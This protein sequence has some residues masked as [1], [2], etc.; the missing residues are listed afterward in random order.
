MEQNPYGVA[1]Q[2]NVKLWSPEHFKLLE[3]SFQQLGRVGNKWLN[4]P[5][6]RGTE[7]GNRDD[8]LIRWVRRRDGSMTYDFTLLDQYLDLAVKYQGIPR[9]INFVVMQGMR[10]NP[11]VDDLVPEVMVFNEG[12]VVVGEAPMVV[13]GAKMS[14]AEKKKIWQPFATALYEHMKVKGLEKAMHWGYPLDSEVDHGFVVMMGEYLPAV[15]WVGGPHQSSYHGYKEPKYYGVIGSVRYFGNLPFFDMRYG[16]K[17]SI[18]HMTIPRIDSSVCSL[19]TASRP[20]GFRV[21]VDHSLAFGRCGFKRVGADEWAS[22]HYDGMR[23][24]TWIVGMPVLHTLWP[25]KNGAESGARFETLIEGVQEGE[26]RLMLAKALD[27]G[28]LKP[29]L[30]KRV[31]KILDRHMETGFFQNKLCIYELEEYPYRWQER[32]REL[33]QMAAEVSRNN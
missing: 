27:G 20:F 1:K 10:F 2:Y 8:S 22:V 25:G 31:R 3:A 14:M 29:E 32:S 28:K 11:D 13:G 18:A 30:A 23:I 24:P 16:W 21:L 15:K 33:Y 7:F 19:V 4:I 26:A 12:G 6:L 9:M 17:G 5:V